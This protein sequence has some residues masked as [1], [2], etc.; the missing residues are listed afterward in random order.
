MFLISLFER[1][2]CTRRC[3]VLVVALAVL[4]DYAPTH[5]LGSGGF[6]TAEQAVPIA[7]LPPLDGEVITAVAALFP[8]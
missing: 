3:Y 2:V 4:L 6:F 5:A 7:K 8:V 1:C